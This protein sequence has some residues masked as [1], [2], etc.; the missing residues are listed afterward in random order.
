MCTAKAPKAQPAPK[1]KPPVY[2]TNPFLDDPANRSV[3]FGRNALRIDRNG[4]GGGYISLPVRTNPSPNLPYNPGLGFGSTPSITYGPGVGSGL[5]I[6][7]RG[8]MSET[9]TRMQVM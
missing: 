4:G 9:Q 2:L 7:G 1:E 6:G 5:G 3:A 8:G